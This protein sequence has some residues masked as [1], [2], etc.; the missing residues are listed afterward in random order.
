MRKRKADRAGGDEEREVFCEK[1]RGLESLK[2]AAIREKLNSRK[3]ERRTC[4]SYA[5]RE[6][7]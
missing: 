6:L 2:R 1:C 7:M 4:D 5:R 3:S